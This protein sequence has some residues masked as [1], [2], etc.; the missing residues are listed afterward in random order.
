[1]DTVRAGAELAS[2]VIHETIGWVV[3][4]MVAN[5]DPFCHTAGAECLLFLH[6]C[7][8]KPQVCKTAAK[9]VGQGNALSLAT[10]PEPAEVYSSQ[11]SCCRAGL[12][13]FADGCSFDA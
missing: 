13:A 11:A 12:G 7:V 2:G 4:G 6:R 3:G 9:Q 8:N 10:S 5:V 1:M